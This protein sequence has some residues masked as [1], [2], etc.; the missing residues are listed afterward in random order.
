VP[1]NDLS[2]SEN[3]E[4]KRELLCTYY[5]DYERLMQEAPHLAGKLRFDSFIKFSFELDRQQRPVSWHQEATF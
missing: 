1:I 5:A 3:Y 2:I 4:H